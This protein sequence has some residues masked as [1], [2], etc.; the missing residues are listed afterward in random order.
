MG[1]GQ[2]KERLRP[3]DSF[4]SESWR[5][6]AQAIRASKV[7]VIRFFIE[8]SSSI[9]RR[10]RCFTVGLFVWANKSQPH[11]CE[12]R[13]TELTRFRL[14]PLPLDTRYRGHLRRLSRFKAAAIEIRVRDQRARHTSLQPA[15]S[16]PNHHSTTTKWVSKVSQ[17]S[18]P[19]MHPLQF[20]YSSSL[21]LAIVR[22]GRRSRR[23]TR[24]T[25]STPC[26]GG[27]SLS[28]RLCPFISS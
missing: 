24:N 2:R 9:S 22:R 4:C 14:H 3:V 27:K 26:L 12:E 8:I 25:K 15:K 18:S 23:S 19:N 1:V 13:R 5:R 6:R 10:A 16:R 21:A 28:T 11:R 7:S 17:V 20:R